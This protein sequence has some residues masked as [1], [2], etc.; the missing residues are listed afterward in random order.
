MP[1]RAPMKFIGLTAVSCISLS[2]PSATD[3]WG[4]EGHQY[5]G[6]LAWALLNPSARSH[7]KAL[8]GAGV[9]LGQA[10][11]WPDCVRSVTGSPS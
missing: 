9:S 7:V 3:A 8:L 5:V 4:S 6:N 2:L 11:V 1:K 10:A